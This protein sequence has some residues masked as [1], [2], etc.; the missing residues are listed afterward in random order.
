MPM[1]T[2]GMAN[3]LALCHSNSL[4]NISQTVARAERAGKHPFGYHIGYYHQIVLPTAPVQ[5][6]PLPTAM[7]WLTQKTV[8]MSAPS[9]I[10]RYNLLPVKLPLASLT[11]AKKYFATARTLIALLKTDFFTLERVPR[12]FENLS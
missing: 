5:T 9:L 3:G 12:Q 11:T 10:A 7:P 2:C 8:Q 4:A 6:S 1:S